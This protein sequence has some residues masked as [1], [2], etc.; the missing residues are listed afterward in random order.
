MKFNDNLL[1]LLFIFVRPAEFFSLFFFMERMTL[2][3]IEQMDANNWAILN[4]LATG[5][6]SKVDLIFL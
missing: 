6:P 4:A 3:H 1:P 2:Y 5:Y